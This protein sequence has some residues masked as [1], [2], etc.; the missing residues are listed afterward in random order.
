ML[1]TVRVHR[2]WTWALPCWRYIA[3]EPGHYRVGVTSQVPWLFKG[4]AYNSVCDYLF[5]R[6]GPCVIR[7]VSV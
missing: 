2:A 7:Y 4:F 1:C 3:G 5:I 6:D